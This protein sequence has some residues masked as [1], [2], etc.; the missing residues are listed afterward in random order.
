MKLTLNIK[1]YAEMIYLNPDFDF[2]THEIK[3]NRDKKQIIIQ[4]KH[5]R[6]GDIK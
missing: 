6:K 1:K 5:K 3:V 2:L 4:L